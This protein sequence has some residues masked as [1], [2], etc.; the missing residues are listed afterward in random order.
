MKILKISKV[1]LVVALATGLSSIL[2]ISA[3]AQ[4]QLPEDNGLTSYH[5]SPRYRESESHPLRIL[6]Y[7]LHPVGWLAREVV[8]RPISYFASSTEVT[9]SVF[10]F[11][12]PFDYRKPECFSAD[13]STPD[14]RSVLPFNYETSSAIPEEGEISDAIAAVDSGRHVYF[15]DV[16]FDFNKRT[17]SSL[18]KGRTKQIAEMLKGDNNVTVV[19]QGHT[20]YKGSDAYNQKLGMDRAEAVKGELVALGVNP[21]RLSTV[22]FGES[23]PA[24]NED[25]D[26]ARAVNRRVETHVSEQ[27]ASR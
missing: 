5:S 25:S 24:V 14:C 21:D 7:V 2:S 9:R 23:R 19:L 12:E 22:S 15:P 20:D 26:W 17:L 1:F 3:H 27:V 6:G 18:G 10:G 13:D 16:N 4:E 8:F 11:R